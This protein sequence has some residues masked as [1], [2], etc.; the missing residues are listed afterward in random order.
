MFYENWLVATENL[1]RQ[2]PDENITLAV[3][4]RLLM[5]NTDPRKI[6]S[7]FLSPLAADAAKNPVYKSELSA[8]KVTI[9]SFA[10][11]NPDV[12][13]IQEPSK[14]MNSLF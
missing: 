8:L 5:P 11:I 1:A 14:Q 13:V 9:E 12:K 3:L 7:F 6:L 4:K 10:K 2:S